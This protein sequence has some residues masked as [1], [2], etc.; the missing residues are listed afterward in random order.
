MGFGG[1]L[2]LIECHSRISA[3]S[4]HGIKMNF[5]IFIVFYSNSTPTNVYFA[6]MRKQLL[7]QN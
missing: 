2:H 1:V 7:I 4:G 6:N 5:L 3:F